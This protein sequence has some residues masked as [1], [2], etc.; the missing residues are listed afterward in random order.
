M[1]D[2]FDVF[3]QLVI[4]AMTTWPWSSSVSVP[5]AIVTGDVVLT[6]SATSAWSWPA[7]LAGALRRR[8]CRAP[9]CSA[10]RWPGTTRRRP[11]PWPSARRDAR[12]VVR[13]LVGA[14]ANS[15]SASRNSTFASS[16]DDA[17]LRAARAGD[18]RDD[19]AEVELERVGERRVLGV[20]VVPEALLLGVR[21]DELDAAPSGGR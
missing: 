7:W 13:V 19:L 21:L 12:L 20:L 9:S 18:R 3:V 17:V 1:T 10:G 6:R 4:A 14:P 16:S 11:P 5:S 8:R 15:C 2:G